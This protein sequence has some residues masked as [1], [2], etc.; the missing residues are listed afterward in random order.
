MRFAENGDLLEFILKNGSI[1]EN[2]A[3]V[4]LRQLALGA[5]LL[6]AIDVS[7]VESFRGYLDVS[8]L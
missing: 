5:F 3:R 7:S 8:F 4:W 1:V 2:Q 6:I